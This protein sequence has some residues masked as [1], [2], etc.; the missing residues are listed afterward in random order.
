MNTILK[1]LPLIL[2]LLLSVKSSFA[3]DWK[4]HREYGDTSI[5]KAK[6]SGTRLT[7]QYRSTVNKQK[8]VYPKEL[9]KRLHKDKKRL[10]GMMGITKWVVDNQKITQKGKDVHMTLKGSYLDSDGLKVFFKEYHY[11]GTSKKLQLLLTNNSQKN[12]EK[13][14]SPKDIA[15]FRVKY[16]F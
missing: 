5:Y 1:T 2:C 6:E 10:L 4:F 9:M 8:V 3:T 16:G 14:L 12:L 11:I 15:G 13:D 7:I